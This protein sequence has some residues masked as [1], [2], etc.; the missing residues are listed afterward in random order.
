MGVGLHKHRAVAKAVLHLDVG[1]AVPDAE[2]GHHLA[3]VDGHCFRLRARRHGHQHAREHDKGGF[4][5]GP[6]VVP[7]HGRHGNLAVPRH[8]VNGV[9][10]PFHKL[11]HE[12]GALTSAGRSSGE[13]A[14]NLC[15]RLA[16]L[17]RVVQQRHVDSSHAEEGLHDDLVRLLRLR[18]SEHLLGR[19]GASLPDGLQTSSRHRLL[20]EVLVAAGHPQLRVPRGVP[21]PAQ[22]RDLGNLLS[23]G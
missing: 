11:L 13:E 18:E 2:R 22:V 14:L 4:A 1:R 9:L 6:A 8:Q 7:C 3:R 5:D 17:G 12:H 15:L 10:L 16:G 19:A 21:T 23:H 20:H